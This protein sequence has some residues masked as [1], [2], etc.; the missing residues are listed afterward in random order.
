MYRSFKSL[1]LNGYY[2]KKTIEENFKRYL[3]KTEENDEQVSSTVL[4]AIVTL[5]STYF[6]SAFMEYE[7][8][9][10]FFPISI[11]IIIFVAW[12]STKVYKCIRKQSKKKSIVNKKYKADTSLAKVKKAI[13]D[14]DYIACD[15]ILVANAFIKNFPSG[16]VTED[17]FYYYEIF[18]YLKS[19]MKR[20]N[21]VLEKP[22]LSI[23]CEARINGI[24][25]YRIYNICDMME[26]IKDFLETHKNRIQIS[27][28]HIELLEC[29]LKS[30]S[31]DLEVICCK[32]KCAYKKLFQV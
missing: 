16:S 15:D 27:A 11:I 28:D 26:N 14:F 22:E 7:N 1:E 8:Y 4:S 17:T 13:D 10:W 25:I 24:D 12:F 2:V 20:V 30:A 21:E 19:A 23:N 18:Y 9:K 5:M 3:E 31:A 6:C 29:Q 32:C